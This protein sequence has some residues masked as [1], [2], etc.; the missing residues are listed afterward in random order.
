MN[1]RTENLKLI[2]SAD[3]KLLGA[4]LGRGE[5]HV[6]N[7]TN[8]VRGYFSKMS[9]HIM[10]GIK[11]ALSSP[12]AVF[13]GG[14]AMLYA[15][16]QIID[17]QDKLSTMGINAGLTAGQLMGLDNAIL[18]NAYSTGQSRDEILAAMNDI[19]DKT[20]DFKFTSD[21]IGGVAKSSTAMSADMLDS[22][23]I[24]SAMKL[25][26][27]ATAGEAES[28]FDIL[29]RMGNIGSFPFAQ[30]AQQAERLFASSTL[31]LGITKK[32]F[33]EYAAFI[34]SVKP[35]FGSGDIAATAIERIMMDMATKRKEVQKAVGFKLFDEKGSIIDFRKTIKA[36][37]KLDIVKRSKLFGEFGRAF[38]PLSS[39]AGIKTYEDYIKAGQEAG[40]ITDAFAK[41]Q[42]EAKFQVN[43]LATAAQQFSNT[44]L[45]PVIKE[46]SDSLVQMTSDPEKMKEFTQSIRDMGEIFTGLAKAMGFTIEMYLKFYRLNKRADFG[47][48]AYQALHPAAARREAE[49]TEQ[50]YNSIPIEQRREIFRRVNSGEKVNLSQYLSGQGNKSGDPG[51]A[52]VN[53]PVVK[54]AINMSI[55]VPGSGPI[56]V[57]TDSKDAVLSVKRGAFN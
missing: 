22:A 51:A 25:G 13:G 21:A 27:G 7:Y 43:A 8:R 36:I 26:M 11:N 53:P 19:F 18:N 20:G 12:L 50:Q 39:E 48:A 16:K 57:S 44:A 45:S 10:G 9:G 30:Q 31:A 14:A 28:L 34:Q 42:T 33:G 46:L 35:V 32:N 29:A 38:I 2:L 54:T 4:E 24:L 37:S 23:R 47:S 40:F 17:Y 55:T 5:Q 52:T 6:K 49:N 56:S 41:K 15:G 1:N 3:G